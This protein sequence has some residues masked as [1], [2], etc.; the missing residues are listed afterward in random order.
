MGLQSRLY[1][2][3][4][5]VKELADSVKKTAI[6]SPQ[7]AAMSDAGMNTDIGVG[8]MGEFLG[9]V[10]AA[11]VQ[12]ATDTLHGGHLS[13]I[14]DQVHGAA[15]F[16]C[17]MAS[18]FGGAGYGLF[19]VP[20]AGASVLITEVQG[21]GWVWFSC[22]FNLEVE[23]GGTATV[24]DPK[25]S[26]SEAQKS[27]AEDPYAKL[28]R[29]EG[30]PMQVTHGIPES[31]LAYQENNE[32][33]QYIWKTPKGHKIVMSEK[34]TENCE[35]KHIT[36]QSAGGK[37]IILDDADARTEIGTEPSMPTG[38]TG[39]RIIIADG[40]EWEEE[41]GPNRIWIQSTAGEEGV[42]DSI[43]VYAR[44]SL[45]L[46]A[47][48][49]NINM[50][51]LDSEV[52]DAHIL[53][54][55][56]ASG[57]LEMDIEEGDIAAA[58]KYRI[59]LNA[60]NEDDSLPH[61]GTIG[62][63]SKGAFTVQNGF[64]EISQNLQMSK[65]NSTVALNAN[66]SGLLLM[67]GDGATRAHLMSETVLI[68]AV[69]TIHLDADKISFNANSIDF[70][71]GPQIDERDF[72]IF[73][74]LP[75]GEGLAPCDLLE[76]DKEIEF[77]T[78]T[79]GPG[80]N[81]NIAE[82]GGVGG[83]NENVTEEEE[84]EDE[85]VEDPPDVPEPRPVEDDDIPPPGIG[86]PGGGSV[87]SGTPPD[88]SGIN[89]V[90][91]PL[92]FLQPI[93]PGAPAG[94]GTSGVLPMPSLPNLPA[95]GPAS[96]PNPPQWPSTP[97]APSPPG[98]PKA[99]STPGT[100]IT[101]SGPPEGDLEVTFYENLG[102]GDIRFTASPP[103]GGGDGPPP[104]PPPPPG[105]GGITKN[106]AKFYVDGPPGGGG[107]GEDD[108]GIIISID[109]AGGAI[110][111]E[112]R[113]RPTPFGGGGED[114]DGIIISTDSIEGGVTHRDSERHNRQNSSFPGGGGGI[115]PKSSWF[116]ITNR[117][118]VSESDN[119]PTLSTAQ[120]RGSIT[121]STISPSQQTT[122]A[123][124]GDTSSPNTQTSTDIPTTATPTTAT[125]G[126][127]GSFYGL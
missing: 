59:C 25:G 85:D 62:M 63:K 120:A 111:T 55:N 123:E 100:P 82:A 24:V 117:G 102:L 95:P 78:N 30:D 37:R 79:N 94:P 118:G 110:D 19:A 34:H 61:L 70:N 20:G 16:T 13:V 52:E 75:I 48:E 103:V 60:W 126:D 66:K 46:E 74:D 26:G 106:D 7:D 88:G 5:Q 86:G 50:T 93:P 51:V 41:G 2:L 38:Q 104:P 31:F 23:A 73:E 43:Q 18:P 84:D 58:A 42:E 32:P 115:V 124:T 47:R 10:Y 21:E 3:E 39:D 9:K 97:N 92:G 91:P 96:T 81:I 57:N 109:D 71:K 65:E 80:F 27:E 99:P 76:D 77:L 67:G 15:A 17:K 12:A 114:D 4:K 121:Y 54:T 44:N 22:L 83:G 116:N 68:T 29:E 98:T 8:G 6:T 14:C 127:A 11:R 112:D 89:N 108:D 69:D 90:P 40:D 1:Y 64:G 56:L 107:G 49:G 125:G 122:T 33:E 105:G 101:P 53:I 87:F 28:G 113:N 45:F 119:I 36:I 35:E 72:A